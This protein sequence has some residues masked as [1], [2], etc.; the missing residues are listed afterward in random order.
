M[1]SYL[2][3]AGMVVVTLIVVKLALRYIPMGDRVLAYL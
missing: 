2:K 3:F 1:K